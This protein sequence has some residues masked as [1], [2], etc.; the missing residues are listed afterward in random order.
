MQ[1]RHKQLTEMNQCGIHFLAQL[2]K[3]ELEDV[4]LPREKEKREESSQRQLCEIGGRAKLQE[5][6]EQEVKSKRQLYEIER[7]IK[8]AQVA[9]CFPF[10]PKNEVTGSGFDEGRGGR[11]VPETEKDPNEN[12]E[13]EMTEIPGKRILLRNKFVIKKSCREDW[14]LP[15]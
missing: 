15:L 2:Q 7:Y 12:F 1:E 13:R 3:K 8:D 6:E 14:L 4:N 5:S 9:M 11:F 10:F